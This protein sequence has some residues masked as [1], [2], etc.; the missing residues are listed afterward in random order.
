[1]LVEFPARFFNW[2][3]R[4]T[5]R[6][7]GS[8][9]LFDAH[10]RSAAVIHAATHVARGDD[11]DQLEFFVSSTT[12]A[13]PQPESRI[14]RAACAAVSC[15]VQHEDASIGSMKS[16]QQLIFFSSLIFNPCGVVHCFIFFNRLK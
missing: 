15:G 9:V 6:R 4:A 10:F 1:M 16:L 12:G 13:Q 3:I 8:H 5:T 7:R 14:A 2:L 11:A